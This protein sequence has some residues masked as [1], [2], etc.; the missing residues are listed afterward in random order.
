LGYLAK[1]KDGNSVL[2][3]GDPIECN[4]S[5]KAEWASPSSSRGGR[6]IARQWGESGTV[7]DGLPEYSESYKVERVE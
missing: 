7:I 6:S 4:P 3:G 2:D 5:P 1:E